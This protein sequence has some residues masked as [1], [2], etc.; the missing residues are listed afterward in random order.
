M[1]V[2]KPLSSQDINLSTNF[3]QSVIQEVVLKPTSCFNSN[4]FS[5]LLFFIVSLW[6]LLGRLIPVCLFGFAL[7]LKLLG[8]LWG[9]V[10]MGNNKAW[11][12]DSL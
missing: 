3:S 2:H 7:I 1:V 6:L 8:L 11:V 4:L 5:F 9:N 10:F 12:S